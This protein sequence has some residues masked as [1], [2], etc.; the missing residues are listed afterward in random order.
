[1]A[2]GAR[3]GSAGH[4]GAQPALGTFCFCSQSTNASRVSPLSQA[5]CDLGQRGRW[6]VQQAEQSHLGVTR[7]RGGALGT[8]GRDEPEPSRM[9]RMGHLNGP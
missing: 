1:M 7:G 5:M 9:A 3:T 6:K 2:L 4:P 8:L